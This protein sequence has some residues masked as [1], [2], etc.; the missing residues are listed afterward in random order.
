MVYLVKDNGK[1]RV[2]YTDK[3]MKAAGFTKSDLSVSEETYNSNGCYARILNGKIQ[4]G[5][6]KD[7]IA[8]EEKQ[9]EIDEL[10]SHLN[11]IYQEVG[12]KE[13]VLDVS[14]SAGVVLDAVRVLLLR[15]AKDLSISLPAGFGADVASAADIL[16]LVPPLNASENEKAD[17]AVHKALLLITHYDPAINPGLTKIREA[18]MAAM[19]IRE[20]LAEITKEND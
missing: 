8:A 16:G 7:E 6:T 13:Y 19:P 10:R 12:A 11:Q 5:K 3:D 4:V 1:V 15:F 18:E 9:K 2:F 20:Q 14:V 17:F